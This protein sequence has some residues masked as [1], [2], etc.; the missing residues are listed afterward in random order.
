MT[1]H[2]APEGDNAGLA[3]GTKIVQWL[4][5]RTDPGFVVA[6]DQIEAQAQRI[7]GL[8]G[9]LRNIAEGNLGE[10]PWQAN[11]DR[12]REVARAALKD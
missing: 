7:A 6:A 1:E 4:R 11:Y 9:S 5:A 2:S 8:E 12:I 10:M 3:T